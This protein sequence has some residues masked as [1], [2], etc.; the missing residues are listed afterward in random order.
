[1]PSNN[2]TIVAGIAAAHAI[3]GVTLIAGHGISVFATML[4]V[5][6]LIALYWLPTFV[7]WKRKHQVLAVALVNG[8]FGWSLIGWVVALV[9]AVNERRGDVTIINTIHNDNDNNG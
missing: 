8:F 6:D 3:A 4:L 2:T 9:M 1:M 7:A 5:V